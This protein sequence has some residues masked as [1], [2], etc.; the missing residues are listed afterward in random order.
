MPTKALSR[1]APS[2]RR[3]LREAA[4]DERVGVVALQTKTGTQRGR[5]GACARL[6]GEARD[7][8][9]RSGSRPSISANAPCTHLLH[10][11][12]PPNQE[13]QLIAAGGGQHRTPPLVRHRLNREGVLP[14][15]AARRLSHARD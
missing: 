6:S 8:L 9:W 15:E 10:T 2:A 12:A 3:R 11:Q 14:S 4:T 1:F 13:Q 5:S 7:R